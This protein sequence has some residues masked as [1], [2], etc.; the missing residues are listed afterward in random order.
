MVE[1]YSASASS[2]NSEDIEFSGQDSDKK[3]SA[4]ESY[5][6]EYSNTNN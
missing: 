4:E 2:N 3:G 5:S 1:Q 6:L